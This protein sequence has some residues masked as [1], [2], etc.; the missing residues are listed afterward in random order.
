MNQ[1]IIKP[2]AAHLMFVKRLVVIMKRA[3]CKIQKQPN[4]Q[5]RFGPDDRQSRVFPLQFL[6]SE[7][8]Q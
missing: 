4:A 5:N 2:L 6:E 1:K 8:N 7:K 3:W